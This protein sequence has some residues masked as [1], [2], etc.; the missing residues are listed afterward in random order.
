MSVK[1]DSALRAELKRL[2]MLIALRKFVD[3]PVTKLETAEWTIRYVL[4]KIRNTPSKAM[5]EY[6][7]YTLMKDLTK[8]RSQ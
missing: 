3:K 5:S 7:E 6:R 8:K 1:S 4:G 2:R